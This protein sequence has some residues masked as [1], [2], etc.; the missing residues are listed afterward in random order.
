MLPLDDTNH[1]AQGLINSDAPAQLVWT[2]LVVLKVTGLFLLAGL[3]EIG[4]GW[5]VWQAVREGRPWWWA[6]A[7][8]VVLV[9][10]GFVPTLQP[11]SDF[12]RLYAVCA[13]LTIARTPRVPHVSLTRSCTAAARTDGGIFIAL[14]YCWGWGFDGMKP[15]L[16]DIIGSLVAVA[17]VCIAL[18]WPRTSSD[19]AG[20]S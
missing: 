11:L 8:S 7:G 17:G 15:D 6:L 19:P 16:G 13:W 14:S 18:F 4:G 10:Y 1:L 12:G 3:A 20:E 9:A 5:L 2:P